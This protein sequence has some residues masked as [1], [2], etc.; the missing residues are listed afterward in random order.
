MFFFKERYPKHAHDNHPKL[1]L[2]TEER[3]INT[4]SQVAKSKSHSL[5]C[6]LKKKYANKCDAL[7]EID[8]FVHKESPTKSEVEKRR[9]EEQERSR[10]EE[11]T[12]YRQE[13][14]R[15]GQAQSRG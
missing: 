11:A 9:K 5:L 4:H 7:G 6:H 12:K 15:E 3:G 1:I 13:E 2:K 10:V 14:G 8:L